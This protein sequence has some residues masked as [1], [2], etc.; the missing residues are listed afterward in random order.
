[1]NKQFAD[2]LEKYL[3]SVCSEHGMKYKWEWF[4]DGECCEVLIS[5]G[6]TEQEAFLN[7]RYDD[8]KGTLSIELIEDCYVNTCE[9]DNT[10][11][12]FWMLVSPVIF[13]YIKE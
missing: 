9:F 7:F 3:L 5:S 4:E 6:D 1:M 12:Y 2:R 11:K 8:E 10:V 13:R